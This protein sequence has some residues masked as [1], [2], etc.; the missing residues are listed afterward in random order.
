MM[1]RIIPARRI[2]ASSAT[3][4]EPRARRQRMLCH[5]CAR[6]DLSSCFMGEP[7]HTTLR[8][9][10]ACRYLEFITHAPD[11]LNI[12]MLAARLN[13]FAQGADMDINN[14]SITIIVVAPDL[15]HQDF[16]RKH[17]ARSLGHERQDIKLGRGYHDLS[18]HNLN[19]PRE[20]I[21]RYPWKADRRSLLQ[22]LI[23]LAG[24]R[25]A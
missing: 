22:R 18:P 15:V 8:A 7:Q 11:G 9:L 23:L 17:P 10:R 6:I 20:A 14:M 4:M 25:L 16:T 5:Q 1:I 19:P 24:M 13:L 3:S 21:H 2:V 12:A